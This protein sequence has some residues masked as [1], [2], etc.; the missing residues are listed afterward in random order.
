MA[1]GRL[2]DDAEISRA[3]SRW[4]TDRWSER[5]GVRVASLARPSAGWSN[6]TFL[7]T[8]A[9]DGG[10]ADA[11]VRLP[12]LVP[13]YPVYDLGAQ[14]R[15]LE[16]LDAAAIPVP[17]P[18][19]F[20]PDESWLGAPFLAMPRVVGRPAGEAPALDP[21]ITDS[22]LATQTHLHQQFVDLLATVHRVDPSSMA[23]VLRGG[24]DTLAA[25]VAW[26]REY[27]EWAADGDVPRGLGDA[28]D[29]CRDHVPAAEPPPSLCW[30]DARLGNVMFDEQRNVTS[31][32]DWELASIGP[33]E[34]DLAWYLALDELVERVVKQRVPGFLERAAVIARYEQH[35]GRPVV[36]LE[37]H[38]VFA[39]ARS[40]TINDRQA[41]IAAAT[42]TDYPGVAGDDNP[43][44]RYL[45]RRIE[46][47]SA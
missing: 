15:V 12:S 17:H 4:A 25:E 14:A 38:E 2:R 45:A 24:A 3:L 22:P 28:L 35:L 39:L 9:W 44:L 10:G 11:V 18:A 7:V 31:V 6:E 29:W 41:R 34:M 37:W 19:T 33:A 32:L 23:G 13:S 43:V 47:A 26:W 20:E 21:W 1:T 40:T 30:G 27:A 46:R 16:A 42:G 36:D 5:A 8:F